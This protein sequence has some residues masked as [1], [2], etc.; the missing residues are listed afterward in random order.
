MTV[1][2]AAW[3]DMQ[4]K[5]FAQSGG[6]TVL[7]TFRPGRS[8]AP[9]GIKA[10]PQVNLLPLDQKQKGVPVLRWRELPFKQ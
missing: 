4:P 6:Q 1:S 2:A 8:T 9:V 7:P 10:H 5:K 3:K